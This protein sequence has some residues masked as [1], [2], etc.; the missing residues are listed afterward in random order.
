MARRDEILCLLARRIPPAQGDSPKAVARWLK[1]SET[2]GFRGLDETIPEN[3]ERLVFEQWVRASSESGLSRRIQRAFTAGAEPR[4]RVEQIAVVPPPAPSP[5]LLWPAGMRQRKDRNP[6]F[7]LPF[8]YSDSGGSERVFC[9]CLGDETLYEV[10]ASLE[11][12]DV[13][14]LPAMRPGEFLELNWASDPKL[15]ELVTYNGWRGLILTHE[16]MKELAGPKDRGDRSPAGQLSNLGPD[17]AAHFVAMVEP[18]LPA[19]VPGWKSKVWGYRLEVRYVH[20]LGRVPGTLTGRLLMTMEKLW[21]RFRDEKG[22]ATDI[23]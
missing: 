23:I 15:N 4:K 17:I 11:G 12:R 14:F 22:H 19:D 9:V 20:G 7:K 13:G 8:L 2:L 1:Q 18:V 6:Q 16:S 5:S 3:G 21:F 10:S